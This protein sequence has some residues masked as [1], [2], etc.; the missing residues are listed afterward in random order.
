MADTE[1]GTRT[2]RIDRMRAF[3]PRKEP[4]VRPDGFVLSDAWKHIAD[5]VNEKRLPMR[6]PVLCLPTEFRCFVLGFNE[7]VLAGDLAG[8]GNLLEVLEPPALREHLALV[9]QELLDLYR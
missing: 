6:A 8:F 7:T 9:A 4:V 2:F 3:D 5:Q 1:N